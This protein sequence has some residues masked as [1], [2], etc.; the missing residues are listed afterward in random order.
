[1]LCQLAREAGGPSIVGQALLTPITDCDFARPSYIDAADGYGLTA[2]LMRWFWGHYTDERDR[3]DPRVSPLRAADLSG[4]PPAV[5]VTCEFDP[6]RDEGQAYAAALEAA[7]VPVVHMFGR[8][9]T[10]TS[11]TMVDQIL[12]G[13]RVRAA[14]AESVRH[15]FSSP[16]PPPL[17]V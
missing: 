4:L 11:L 16:A 17:P 6:L 2:E 7:G 13:S 3:R 5:V 15:F 10:H 9:H 12:S 1:V 8:G 14:M